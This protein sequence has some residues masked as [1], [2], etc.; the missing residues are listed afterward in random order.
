MIVIHRRPSKK[1]L[2]KLKKFL[3]EFEISKQWNREAW[4]KNGFLWLV[5]AEEEQE[6]YID[7]SYERINREKIEACESEAKKIIFG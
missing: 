6:K 3:G 1:Y 4:Q 5:N 7:F 2:Q